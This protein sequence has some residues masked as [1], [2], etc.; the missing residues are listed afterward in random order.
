[1]IDSA[2]VS[3]ESFIV[4]GYLYFPGTSV[5]VATSKKA[6]TSIYRRLNEPL[7]YRLIAADINRSFVNSFASGVNH[8]DSEAIVGANRLYSDSSVKWITGSE[9][10][11]T[12]ALSADGSDYYFRTEDIR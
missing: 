10:N 8:S 1:M 2:R 11:T 7:G 4:I 3:R 6:A 9:F 12:K 5:G